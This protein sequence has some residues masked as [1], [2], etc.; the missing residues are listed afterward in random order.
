[1]KQLFKPFSGG[2]IGI[3]AFVQFVILMIVWMLAPSSLFPSPLEV[4]GSWN[5]LATG[6]SLLVELGSSAWTILRALVYSSAIGAGIAYLAAINI[7]KP[8][9]NGIAALRFLGFA[10]ITFMFTMMTGD[11][12]S[13]KLWLL[14]FGM[15][16]F[17]VTN[18]LAVT[19]SITQ[20][21]VDY[22][23]T[24]RLSPIRTVYELLIRGKSHDFLDIIRQNAA[25]GWVMLSMVEGLV[26]SEGGIGSLLLTQ[27]KFLNLS[28]IAA[29][30]ITILLYGI[31]QDYILGLIR[32]LVCP[33]LKY[34]SVK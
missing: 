21:E 20:A 27:S 11:G 3:I 2:S 25:I 5:N 24:L 6:Q 14:T 9:A 26:R 19:Y 4:L 13:L 8:V 31:F 29:I 10:G 30:Q 33:Y 23:R 32:L 12:G 17:Q 34:T 15:L 28:S 7:I 18:M 22:A 1:M 16:V